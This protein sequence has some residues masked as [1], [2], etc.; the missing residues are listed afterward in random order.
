[1][2]AYRALL[3]SKAGV[4]RRW[5]H[6]GAAAV[7]KEQHGHN[8]RPSSRQGDGGAVLR[9]CGWRRERRRRPGKEMRA[10][11]SERAS[12][13]RVMV[14]RGPTGRAISLVRLPRSGQVLH[15]S[16][17]D[18]QAEQAIRARARAGQHDLMKVK[19]LIGGS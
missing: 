9:C 4:L 17:T 11:G 7:A 13:G 15:R 1:M 10:H 18:G 3:A 8:A 14:C 6:D 19:L 16:A 2:E 12:A 5:E